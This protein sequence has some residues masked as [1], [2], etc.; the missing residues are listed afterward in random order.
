VVRFPRSRGL[1]KAPC[2]T[3]EPFGLILSGEEKIGMLYFSSSPHADHSPPIIPK[4]VPRPQKTLAVA[5]AGNP[6]SAPNMSEHV[7]FPIW[8]QHMLGTASTVD[9][10]SAPDRVQAPSVS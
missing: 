5:E 6:R 7:P 2:R 9:Y 8:L 3:Y 4:H 1:G 10:A